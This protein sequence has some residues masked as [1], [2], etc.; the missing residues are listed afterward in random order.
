MKFAS[1]VTVGNPYLADYAYQ[2]GAEN[3][4]IIPT[5]VD[6][7][8][9]NQ[10]NYKPEPPFKIGWIGS[11]ATVRYLELVRQALNN[12][13]NQ[14]DI[15]LITIGSSKFNSSKFEIIHKEWNESTEVDDLFQ[16]D[17]GIMPLADNPFER[18]KCGYKLIQ[19]MASKKPV[20]ASPVGVN[21]EIVTSGEN[22]FLADSSEAWTASFKKLFCNPSKMLEFGNKG[23]N[24]VEQKYNLN[25]TAPQILGILKTLI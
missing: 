2:S 6:L 13:S 21:K 15:R 10:R 20:I 5:V 9:Y 3:V 16:I 25:K 7:E 18:G 24:L 19:Y 17:V 14:F 11:P 4:H 8:K 12:I 22:G 23:Y 1:V